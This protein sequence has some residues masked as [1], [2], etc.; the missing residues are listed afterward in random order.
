MTARIGIVTVSD[1]ASRGEYEDLGGPAIKAYLAEVL[2]SDWQPVARVISDDESIIRDTLIDERIDSEAAAALASRGHR[3]RVVQDT[4]HEP[5][6]A[7]PVGLWIDPDG[8]TV[9]TGVDVLRPACG[10]GWS[11]T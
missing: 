2:R 3:V 4:L 8:A 11:R 9:S 6:F 5:L 7:R 1:R 10:L